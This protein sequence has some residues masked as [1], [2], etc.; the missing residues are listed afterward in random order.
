MS[1]L[2]HGCKVP[3]QGKNRAFRVAHRGYIVLTQRQISGEEEGL[4]VKEVPFS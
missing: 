4:G 1:V 2:S 3:V